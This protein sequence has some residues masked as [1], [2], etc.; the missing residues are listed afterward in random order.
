MTGR[1]RF[2]WD[3]KQ[4]YAVRDSLKRRGLWRYGESKRRKVAAPKRPASDDP[5]EGPS[6]QPPTKQ[7]SKS[8]IIGQHFCFTELR[9]IP[10]NK[11]SNIYSTRVIFCVDGGRL[12]TIFPK[13]GT[14]YLLHIFRNLSSEFVNLNR[15]LGI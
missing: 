1:A 3:K 9:Q 7:P 11:I 2:D 10:Q 12:I 4:W 5:G 14:P 13:R 8:W 6:D 15:L